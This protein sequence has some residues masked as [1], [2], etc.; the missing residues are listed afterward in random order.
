VVDDASK[1]RGF[2]SINHIW[3]NKIAVLMGDYLLSKGLLLATKEK[4]YELL[5][6]ISDATK[7][8]SEGELL[9]IQKS[10]SLNI[11]E[12]EYLNIIKKKTA[13]LIAACCAA[14]AHSAKADE[15]QIQQMYKMGEHIGIAF[16]IRH[17][18]L[19][20]ESKSASGKARNIDLKEK[21]IT[22]PL[23]YLLKSSDKKQ[24]KQIVKEIKKHHDDVSRMKKLADT[25]TQSN[26]V[27]Y[28][29]DL[30]EKH[31]QA[32]FKILET[33]DDGDAKLLMRKLIKYTISRNK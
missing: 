9:Q 32:A 28:A 7:E 2:F 29:W 22:L 19:D 13:S 8:M 4:E 5:D 16:Q 27:N 33:F 23:I 15:N 17:D 12:E 30:M 25:I 21:K 18:L 1:R 6:I 26:G 14:G 10:R 3:K 31:K 20:I 11:N 24:R